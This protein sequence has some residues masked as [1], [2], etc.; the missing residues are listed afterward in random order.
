MREDQPLH[1]RGIARVHRDALRIPADQLRPPRAVVGTQ[2]LAEVVEQKAQHQHQ[3]ALLRAG[4]AGQLGLGVGE[5][6]GAQPHQALQREHRVRVDRV[7]VVQAVL[8]AR[9]QAPH[10][11]KERA[12]DAQLVKR[13]ERLAF[14]ALAHQVLPEL[15][16]RIAVGRQARPE[17]LHLLHQQI[18]RVAVHRRPV[19]LGDGE[20]PHQVG[21]PAREDLAVVHGDAPLPELER[22]VD[23]LGRDGRAP[24]EDPGR[25]R[26]VLDRA[27]IDEGVGSAGDLLQRA[28]LADRT[29]M[30]R[31]WNLFLETY[32]LVLTPFL[33]RP[34]YPWNYDAQGAAQVKDLF[35]AAVYS[36]G[37]NY[38]ALPAGVVPIDLVEDLPAG[39]QLVG[40]RF[41]EDTILD[42][43]AAVEQRAGSLVEQL[44]ART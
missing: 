23:R 18:A 3:R 1:V 35:D 34:T 37:I 15:E 24:A 16:M 30:I 5:R 26:R 13:R 28:G 33:M 32:P 4:D 10:L 2:P 9:P 38:L 27:P 17:P 40:R 44:W 14:A 12:E 7:H 31:A 39:V 6:A 11:G 43:M 41:R 21:G 19:G 8:R 20:D 42:A 25:A 29:R 36:Y 22:V